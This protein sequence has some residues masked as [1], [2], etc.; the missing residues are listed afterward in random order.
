MSVAGDTVTYRQLADAVDAL[1]GRQVRRVEWS[2]P[3]LQ[4]ELA[5]EPGSAIRKYRVVFAQ[6]AG[7]SWNMERTFNGQRG[8]AVCGMEQWMRENLL[9][10][11]GVSLL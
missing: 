6:G 4:G 5:G 11:E 10:R 1:L 2:V 7:V 3:R 9:A 8:I